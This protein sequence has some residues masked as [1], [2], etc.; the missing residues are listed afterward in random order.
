MSS[1][2]PSPSSSAGPR[3][4]PLLEFPPLAQRALDLLLGLRAV[5]R[6]E[7]VEAH[8]V[9]GYLREVSW[10]K[11]AVMLRAG[12]Q[13]GLGYMLLLLEGEVAVYAEP[14]PERDADPIAV[15]S[16]GSLV[17]EMA[18]VDGSAPRSAT[19][20]AL[21]PVRAAGL[22][23]RGLELLMAEH[24]LVGAKL[25]AVVAQQLADRLRAI[26]EQ[27][28]LVGRLNGQLSQELATLREAQQRPR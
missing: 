17:G 19:C 8:A 10:S 21:S 23:R 13:S 11:S 28:Q 27:L 26:G 24:P 18:L 12:D 6:L 20:I 15:L 3:T 14:Q 4:R 25:M 5:V 22:S 1:S 2:S 16:A 9:L 7:P